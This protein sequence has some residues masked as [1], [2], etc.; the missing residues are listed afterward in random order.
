MNV[1]VTLKA[2]GM[3]L[4]QIRALLATNSPPLAR[5]LQLQLQVCSARKGAA[6]K[7]VGLVKTVLAT[8]ESGRSLS[9]DNL[10]NLT[11]SMEMDNQPTRFQIVRGLLNE[12]L[13]PEE[14]RAVMTWMAARP[15]EEMKTMRQSVPEARALGLSFQDLWEKKVDPAAPAA[16]ELVVRRN[17]LAVRYGLRNH[18]AAL[19]EWN[20]PVALKWIQFAE[21]LSPRIIPSESNAPV[22]AL[23]AFGRAAEVASPW[24]RAL[25]PIVEEAAV[26]VDKKEHP[27]AAPAQALAGRVRRICADHSLGDPL[28]YG[29]WARGMQVRWSAEDNARKHA[30]WTFL[31][32]AIEAAPSAA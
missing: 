29:R 22:E 16:Q 24:Y 21:R 14:E 27:S 15:Q 8:I 1:I 18:L 20:T 30:G 32:N 7:A 23:R 10:C 26:L 3:T 28:V 12:E 9:Q 11:R 6:D 25:E 31:I 13:T 19:L 2:F 5:V 17:E 4:A